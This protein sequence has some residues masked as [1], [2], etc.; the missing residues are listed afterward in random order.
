MITRILL[1]CVGVCRAAIWPYAI[2]TSVL[3]LQFLVHVS[4]ETESTYQVIDLLHKALDEL[5][6][7]GIVPKATATRY[8]NYVHRPQKDNIPSFVFGSFTDT[9]VTLPYPLPDLLYVREIDVII[10]PDVY[11]D[12]QTL[13]LTVLHELGH[14]YGLDHPS[15][16][17]SDTVMG[18]V[19]LLNSTYHAKPLGYWPKLTQHDVLQLYKYEVVM[20]G[21]SPTQAN[22]L[23]RSILHNYPVKLSD[24]NSCGVSRRSFEHDGIM[25]WPQYFTETP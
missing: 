15:V 10:N 19:V 2:P 12:R 13:Y 8:T 24:L 18:S 1:V 6:L 9:G 4:D 16:H 20:Y 11:P 17:H 21:K 5:K 7:P 22:G 25:P 23:I 14:V 3:P